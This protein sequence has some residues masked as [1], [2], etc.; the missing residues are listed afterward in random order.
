MPFQPSPLQEAITSLTPAQVLARAKDFFA[1]RSSLYAAFLD[2]EG[3]RH[4]TFRGQGGEE[5]ALA[6]DDAPGVSGATRVTASTYLFDMQVARFLASLP[7]A[8]ESGAPILS[9]PSA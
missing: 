2:Q 7:P 9:P 6:V 3:E 4:A 5:I 8:P 1:R